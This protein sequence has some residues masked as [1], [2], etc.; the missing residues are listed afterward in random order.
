A[1][2]HF[3][4]SLIRTLF[5]CLLVDSLFLHIG[6]LFLL[7]NL[8]LQLL[9]ALLLDHPKNWG[10]SF[11]AL[12]QSY[13]SFYLLSQRDPLESSIRSRSLSNACFT[14]VISIFI[15]PCLHLFYFVYSN[16]I[17]PWQFLYFFPLPHGQGSL[18]PT[19]SFFTYGVFEFFFF[20]PSPD[21]AWVSF[22]T[23]S[24]S[25]FSCI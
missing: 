10:K 25:K 2:L 23:A 17:F 15:R 22:T 9:V 11:F 8:L 4:L 24:L 1:L 21:T 19:D 16:H 7:T 3:L 14:S 12:I 20:S 6:L 13:V 5:Q 18:R